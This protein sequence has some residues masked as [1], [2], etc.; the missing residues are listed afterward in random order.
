[1]DEASKK[2]IKD[3][4]SNSPSSETREDVNQRNLVVPVPGQDSRSLI[5]ETGHTRTLFSVQCCSLI[6]LQIILKKM[7]TSFLV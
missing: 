4:R 3:I 6:V 7:I 1:M 2:E 5:V